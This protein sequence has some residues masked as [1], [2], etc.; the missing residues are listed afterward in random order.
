MRS[1][2]LP[3]L[4]PSQP[5]SPPGT[6]LRGGESSPGEQF[7]DRRRAGRGAA[8]SPSFP[9][10]RA[11]SPPLAESRRRRRFASKFTRAKPP[12]FRLF[13]PGHPPSL[14]PPA[15]ARGSAVGGVTYATRRQ[16]LT[17]GCQ[18]DGVEA[19]MVVGSVCPPTADRTKELKYKTFFFEILMFL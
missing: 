17:A 8:R 3:A 18:R 9:G 14:P 16:R 7:R 2:T 12:V 11:A 6:A 4:I 19:L 5:G 13:P 10:S 1:L 15:A